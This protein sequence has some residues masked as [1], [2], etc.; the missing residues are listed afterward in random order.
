MSLLDDMTK[1]RI[2][3]QRLARTE[4][5]SI[6]YFL[7]L[8]E[9]SA[10]KELSL[11][12]KGRDLN[13]RLRDSISGL[14]KTALANMKDIAQYESA[15]SVK[16][17]SKYI[18]GDLK[19]VPLERLESQ[20]LTKNIAVNNVTISDGVATFSNEVHKSLEVAYR[21]FGQRK[22]DELTQII[23]D[24]IILKLDNN[25]TEDKISERV[26]GLQ[27]TQAATLAL[28]AINYTTNVAKEEVMDVNSEF[29]K[30]EVWV[31]QL[32]ASTCGYCEDLHGTVYDEGD[33]PDCPAHW[34]CMCEVI[35]YVPE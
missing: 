12:T 1:H 5:T 14:S 28:T 2:F 11:G 7:K 20:L 27:T 33:A 23:K 19:T 17:F 8:L 21:Q 26:S 34:N 29:I 32:E 15:F 18:K 3:V 10:K 25:E 35:P 13:K 16:T 31:S 6:K 24:S 4:L 30:E 9:K 22:A